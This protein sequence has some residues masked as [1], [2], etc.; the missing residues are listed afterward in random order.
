M[1]KITATVNGYDDEI[2]IE[3]DADEIEITIEGDE[4]EL[5]A[6]AS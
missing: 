5:E 2:T 1:S 6:S 3:L 4:V